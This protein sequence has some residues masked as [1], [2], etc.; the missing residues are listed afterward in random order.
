MLL[1]AVAAS[2]ALVLIHAALASG[3]NTADL[4]AV[5]AAGEDV[6]AAQASFEQ[7]LAA[8]PSFFYSSVWSDPADGASEA[9]RV[10]TAGPDSGTDIQPGSSW[11]AS[12]GDSWTYAA[13]STRPLVEAEIIPPGLGQATLSVRF[14][15]VVGS[16][17]SGQVVTYRYGA[18]GRLSVYSAETLPLAALGTATLSG[19]VYSGQQI[20]LPTSS[21]V[22]VSGATLAAE[23]GFVGSTSGTT[24]SLYEANPPSGTTGTS[25]TPTIGNIRTLLPTPASLS[26]L[27]AE[28]TRLQA[29]GCPGAAPAA[30]PHSTD[31][32]GPLVTSLCLAKGASVLPD[33]ASTPVTVPADTEAYLLAFGHTPTATGFGTGSQNATTVDVYTSSSQDT[34]AAGGCSIRCSPIALAAKEA[35]SGSSPGVLPASG[36]TGYHWRFLG[37]FDLPASGV[38]ATDAETDIG[39][40]GAAFLTANSCQTITPETPGA[41]GILSSL[42]V[43]A[44]TLTSPADVYF[45][46]PVVSDGGTLGVVA[47]G[48]VVLPYWSHP[49]EGA[50]QIDAD[51]AALGLDHRQDPQASAL[52]AYPAQ[53]PP[54][55]S[56]SDPNYASKLALSGTLAAPALDLELPGYAA[57]SY[58]PGSAATPPPWMGGFSA[59]FRPAG[60]A[61]MTPAQLSAMP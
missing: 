5:R 40:C 16:A 24:A 31:A 57:T 26:S 11:P 25:G 12:C 19:I 43:V 29:L 22:N 18:T 59:S 7:S 55:S 37:T 2:I 48:D 34:V 47:T 1:S 8:N 32:A 20:E 56:P 44:G 41:T 51:I 23:G 4:S 28:V 14:A 58:S 30:L 39:S 10:C 21:A 9:A 13:P 53:L 15:A 36:A 45:D 60:V 54:Q 6:A 61:P 33:N 42:T 49:E 46:G 50:L 52:V 38:I 3:R 17:A 27:A 35:S